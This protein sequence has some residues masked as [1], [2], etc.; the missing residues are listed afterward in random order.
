MHASDALSLDTAFGDDGKVSIGFTAGDDAGSKLLLTLFAMK[1]HRGR[2]AIS[3][4]KEMV[5]ADGEILKTDPGDVEKS[6]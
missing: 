1:H 5:F 4:A 2:S 3:G 6:Q